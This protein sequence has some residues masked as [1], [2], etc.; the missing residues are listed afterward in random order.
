ME[1]G[2]EW[3]QKTGDEVAQ[4]TSHPDTLLGRVWTEVTLP[5]FGCRS[6]AYRQDGEGM[7]ADLKYISGTEEESLWAFPKFGETMQLALEES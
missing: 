7:D 4:P 2:D 6:K 3:P 1:F 5:T